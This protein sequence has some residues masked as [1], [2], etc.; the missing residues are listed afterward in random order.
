MTVSVSDSEFVVY[1]SFIL[2]VL[3]VN[4]APILPI[5]TT[6]SAFADISYQI[7]INVEDIDD[8]NHSIEVEMDTTFVEYSLIGNELNISPM[9]NWYGEI[10][11]NISISDGEFTANQS[12]NV[13][14]CK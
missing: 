13:V 1:E 11:V 12:F 8:N 4:D 3:P 2:D 6:Q 14:V 9:E 10:L 7:Q 5:L